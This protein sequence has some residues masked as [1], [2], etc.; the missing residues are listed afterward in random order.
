MLG[1]IGGVELAFLSA[2]TERTVAQSYAGK[3]SSKKKLGIVLE[4]QPGLVD[5]AADLSWLS[6]HPFEQLIVFVPL[7][8][9]E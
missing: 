5:R 9:L 6:Q 4:I 7:T 1:H 2:T 8:A 3:G